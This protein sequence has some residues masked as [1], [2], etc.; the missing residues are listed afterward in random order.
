M[1]FDI[2]KLPY[3]NHMNFCSLVVVELPILKVI[4][5]ATMLSQLFQNFLL[6]KLRTD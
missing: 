6:L 5:L 4:I 3:L 2:W 1:S